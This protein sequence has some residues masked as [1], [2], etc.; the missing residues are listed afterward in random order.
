VV[1]ASGFAS[2][3]QNRDPEIYAEAADYWRRYLARDCQ[4]ECGRGLEEAA[5][6]L[7]CFA[8]RLSCFRQQGGNA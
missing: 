7:P 2:A 8:C 3:K 6:L 5:A 4:S 1:N